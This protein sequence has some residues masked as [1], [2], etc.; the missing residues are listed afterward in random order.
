MLAELRVENLG[1][2]DELTVCIGSGMT[3]ITGETGA[4]KTLLIEAV[5]LLLGARADA[6]LIRDGASEARVDGRFV[7]GDDEWVLSR[8]VPREGRS[9]AYI[10]GRPTTA[11]EL[12]ERGA[13]FVDLH[14]QHEHQSLLVPAVQRD[15]LD[16]W[17][18]D[19]AVDLRNE[20]RAARAEIATL[21]DALAELGGDERSRA[22]EIDLLRFQV[23]EI[24]AAAI[25]DAQEAVRLQAEEGLLG[26]A[27][28]HRDALV[29]ARSVLEERAEDAVGV[30]IAALAGRAPF[31]AITDRIRAAQ[32]EIA[33]L[34]H[35]LRIA[36]ESLVADPQRLSEVRERL[37]RL[38]ELRRKYG[39]SL[40]EV[41]EYRAASELRLAQLE[42]HDARAAEID[43]RRAALVARRLAA[44]TRLSELR[45]EHAPRLGEAVTRC[46]RDL[47]LA[48]ATFSISIRDI[49]MPDDVLDADV[50]DDGTDL[51]TFCLT[52]NAGEP[53]RSLAKAASGGELSRTMLAIRSVLS[54]APPTLVFDEVDSGIGGEAGIA[55]GAAL[56]D[57]GADHQVLCVT[58]LAQVAAHADDQIH[59]SKRSHDGR[60][61][62]R[63]ERLLDEARVA[64]LSRM[65]GGVVD[66][67][68]ARS[69]AE[70][71]LDAA[72]RRGDVNEQ[73]RA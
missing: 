52:A 38:R 23:E 58:H 30:A 2:I 37:L 7:I 31:D 64:E 68:H 67:A 41:L 46:L 29:T 10:N 14:G 15:L 12:A 33:D 55:V 19:P 48:N 70:E 3:A 71:L 17:I 4:G 43:Q 50:R 42:S 65:L 51:V 49:G 54:H 36:A 56:A 61:V 44:A 66:S 47:A 16:T 9:R 39:E 25:I 22:R 20:L 57:L 53:P 34:V 40:S 69:H 59:V 72:R 27:E 5:Q 32:G 18:G 1:I 63:A 45:V 13:S 73:V 62:A 28:S 8:V 35:E 11:A 24:D 60:T 26:D 6:G 21:D